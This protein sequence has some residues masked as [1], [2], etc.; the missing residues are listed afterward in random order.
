[1][2]TLARPAAKA[3]SERSDLERTAC[4][5]VLLSALQNL[6][7]VCLDMEL[8]QAKRPTEFQYLSAMR[9][10]ARAIALATGSAA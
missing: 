2:S 3:W 7:K 1:M 8:V 5:A 6:H 4:A 9:N 10:A